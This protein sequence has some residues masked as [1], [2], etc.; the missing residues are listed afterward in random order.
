MHGDEFFFSNCMVKIYQIPMLFGDSS[1][2]GYK[3]GQGCFIVMIYEKQIK[4]RVAKPKSNKRI[5]ALHEDRKTG[6]KRF[7]KDQLM[8]R[9]SKMRRFCNFWMILFNVRSLKPFAQFIK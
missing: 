2:F 8:I 3:T 4:K 7:V 9:E 1:E 6:R 5:K